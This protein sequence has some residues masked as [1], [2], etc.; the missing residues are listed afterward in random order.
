MW[1]WTQYSVRGSFLDPETPVYLHIKEEVSITA[2]M[3]F[4]GNL[5][6]GGLEED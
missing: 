5:V 6:G 1:A 2:E 4:A 3:E